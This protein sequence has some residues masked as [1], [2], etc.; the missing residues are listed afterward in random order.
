MIKR[1]DIKL[2]PLPFCG[3]ILSIAALGNLLQ[4]YHQQ[5]R[6][7]CGIVSA[8]FLFLMILQILMNPGH[9]AA[10]LKETAAASVAGTFS[11]ALMVLSGY[12]RDIW[13]ES[14]VA[15]WYIGIILHI[16]ESPV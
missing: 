13:G 6:F 10:S 5:L 1:R 16:P 14:A 7:F 9:I 12:A 11:M 4:S 15:V 3:V 2:L 8:V